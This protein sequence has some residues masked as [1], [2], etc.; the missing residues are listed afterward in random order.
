M[1]NKTS[2]AMWSRGTMALMM[3]FN[4]TCKPAVGEKKHVEGKFKPIWW[5]YTLLIWIYEHVWCD[6]NL[7]KCAA[8]LLTGYSWDQPQRSQ[9]TEG[10]KGFNIETSRFP[11]VSVHWWMA[12]F[13]VSLLLFGQK[14]QDNTEESVTR[15]RGG[16]RLAV[17]RR[18]NKLIFGFQRYAALA[19]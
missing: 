3:E 10:S 14:L 2:R 6:V 5:L 19:W 13:S 12:T 15:E 7:L 8:V 9:H 18:W 16:S 4:T 1:T 11:S 17:R